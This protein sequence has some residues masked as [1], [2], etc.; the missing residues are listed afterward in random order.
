M[1]E[2]KE[3]TEKI[4]L[5]IHFHPFLLYLVTPQEMM[6]IGMRMTTRTTRIKVRVD[7]EVFKIIKEIQEILKIVIF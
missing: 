6:S 5:K 4:N 7:Q 2:T 1:E 3:E